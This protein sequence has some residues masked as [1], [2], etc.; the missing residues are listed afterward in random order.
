MRFAISRLNRGGALKNRDGDNLVRIYK[1]SS[2]FISLFV[3]HPEFD[4]CHKDL[5]QRDRIHL[6]ER[7]AGYSGSSGSGT[8]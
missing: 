6:L 1:H 7:P 8:I 4:Q 3:R 5:F 2:G